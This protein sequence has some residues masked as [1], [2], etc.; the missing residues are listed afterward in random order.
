ETR[1]GVEDLGAGAAAAVGEAGRQEAVERR[2]GGEAGPGEEGARRV[3]Q[4]LSRGAPA[5]TPAR[6]T[7]CTCA[8]CRTGKARSIRP[9][10]SAGG[11]ALA[12]ESRR[13]RRT[14]V[15]PRAGTSR[16][17]GARRRVRARGSGR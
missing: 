9:W 6:S 1:G 15:R 3:R 11:T 5:L 16:S 10:G 12:W 4:E 14:S 2:E 8:R 13:R 7:F 17:R